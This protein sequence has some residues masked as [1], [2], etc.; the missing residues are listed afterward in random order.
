MKQFTDTVGEL[1][2]LTDQIGES[3]NKFTYTVGVSANKVT[4]R[5]GESSRKKKRVTMLNVIRERKL[6]FL[7]EVNPRDPG[8]FVSRARDLGIIVLEGAKDVVFVDPSFYSGFLERLKTVNT[9][10]E[11]LIK[12][13]FSNDYYRLFVFLREN[14]LIYFD[15]SER[16]W[17]L[18]V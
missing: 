14:G 18:I 16:V 17:K 15:A 2:K 6:Q 7:S 10:N 13:R 3:L 8:K 11:E 12:K 4:D 9:S 5:V 1:H